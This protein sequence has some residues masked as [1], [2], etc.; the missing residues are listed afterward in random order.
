MPHSLFLEKIMTSIGSYILLDCRKFKCANNKKGKC[1]LS[2]VTL[3]DDGS[4]IIGQ[5]KCIEAEEKTD[6]ESHL[7][8]EGPGG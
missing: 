2:R 6:E 7:Q 4:P 8:T 1:A 5:V 3:A